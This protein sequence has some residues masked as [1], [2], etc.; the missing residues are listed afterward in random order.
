MMPP[1]LPRAPRSATSTFW[2]NL[3]SAASFALTCTRK[4]FIYE[5][6]LPC[7]CASIWQFLAHMQ[8]GLP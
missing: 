6:S 7:I 4:Q 3:R 2:K 8:M 5:S 1:V